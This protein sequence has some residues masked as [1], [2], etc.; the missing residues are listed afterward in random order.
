[1]GLVGVVFSTVLSVLR[2][3]FGVG[4]VNMFIFRSSEL[5]GL[6]SG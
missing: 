4:G 2:G 6:V 3:G 1:M 5:R